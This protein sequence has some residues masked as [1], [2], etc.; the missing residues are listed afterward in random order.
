[1]APR[2]RRREAAGLPALQALLALLIAGARA[3]PATMVAGTTAASRLTGDAVK[4]LVPASAP[5]TTMRSCMAT[6]KNNHPCPP[7]VGDE[8][9]AATIA[10]MEAYN[11]S[12]DAERIQV[13]TRPR[14]QAGLGMA[15]VKVAYSAVN[16]VN[17]KLLL[18]N[19]PLVLYPQAMGNDFAGTVEEVGAGC[20]LPVGAE[21]WGM[22]TGAYS[23][24]VLASCPIVGRK[25]SNL[26]MLQS[27]VMPLVALTGL[28]ALQWAGAP[29]TD[30]PTVLVLG[31]SGGT[32]SVALQLA[33]AMGAARVITTCSPSNFDYV[34]SLGAD[35]VIDYHTQ[36]WWEVIPF[37]VVNVIYDCVCELGTGDHAYQILADGGRFVTIQNSPLAGAASV[38]KRPSVHQHSF[39]L[40]QTGRDQ[41]DILKEIAEAGHLNVT[42]DSVF[43]LT[44]VPSAFN[45]S[46][47][48]H[49]LGKIAIDT[50]A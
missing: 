29:W 42:I 48:A 23:E 15:L 43:G 18:H 32:G 49:T 46:M 2:H 31:G 12:L 4:S 33:K 14:P 17:W 41:L 38:A 1:M 9:V 47:T 5:A 44:S 50:Q 3:L 28:E 24:Y 39:L 10:D 22:T 26:G 8:G 13:V 35:Q 25:P 40:S 37:G 7:A 45:A 36:N 21:V 6:R 20:D 34:R 11:C 30:G 19:M 27:G 16:P